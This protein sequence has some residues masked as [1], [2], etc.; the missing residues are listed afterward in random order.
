MKKFIRYIFLF[1]LSVFLSTMTYGQIGISVGVSADDLVENIVG[2]GVVYSNAT[3]NGTDVMH[4]TFVNGSTT[5][6]GIDAGIF[7]TSGSGIFIPGP[8]SSGS[9]STNNE[10]PGDGSLSGLAGGTT[11]DASVLE[12]DFIPESDTLRFQYSFGSDEYNEFVWSSYNDVFGFFVSGP[13]PEGGMY[14]NVNVAVVPGSNPPVPVAINT[15]NNDLNSE[16]YHENLTP[17]TT[18]EY[19]GFT[20]VLTA[21]IRVVPCEEYHIK[22]GVADVADGIYDSGIFL[23]EN[24]FES[25]KIDVQANP[26]PEGVADNMVEGC[27]EA[28]VVFRLPNTSYTPITVDFVVEGTAEAPDDYNSLGNSVT[29][30]EGVDSVSLH[31][32]PIA[33]YI[34]EGDEDIMIIITNTLGCTVRIDTVSFLIKDY[35][36]L[37]TESPGEVQLCENAN[38]D[39]TIHPTGGLEPFTFDWSTGEEADT[40]ETINVAPNEDTWYY[41]TVSDMCGSEVKDSV[42]VEVIPSPDIDLGNDTTLC[43]G[44]ELVLDAGEGFISYYW[45]T[46]STEQSITVTESGNYWVQVIGPG[47]CSTLDQINVTFAPALNLE[48]GND[49]SLCAGNTLNLEAPSGMQSYLWQDGSTTSTLEVTESGTYWVNIESSIGCSETD[50]IHVL[51]EDETIVDLGDDQWICMGD[52]FVL[53]PG[54]YNQYEWQDGST[55]SIYTVT[56]AGTYILQALGGCGW[57]SDT[58][59]INYHPPVLPDLGPDTTICHTDSYVLNPGLF[60]NP[61]WQDGTVANTYPV[62]ETGTYSV[63]VTALTYACTGSDTVFVRV[64]QAVQ[65]G[66]DTSFCQGD[67]ITLSSSNDFDYFEWTKDNDAEILS[68]SNS[69]LVSEEGNYTISVGINNINCNSSDEI[70]VDEIPVATADLEDG[71]ICSGETMT[72]HVDPDSTYNYYW[73]GEEGDHELVVSETG[74][75]RIKVGN[76]CGYAYDTAN[77]TVYPLPEVDL[78][79]DQFLFDENG[80]IILNAGEGFTSYTWQD[81]SSQSTYTITYETAL[82]NSEYFV[83]VFDGNCYATDSIIVE[84][85]VPEIPNLLSP[86]GDGYNDVFKPTSKWGAI[87]EHTIVIFNRWGERVWQSTDFPSGWNGENGFGRKVSNGTY[88]WVLEANYGRGIKRIYKGSLTVLNSN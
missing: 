75:Y 50:T 71:S 2:D 24:S 17:P 84:T 43:G 25:P 42:F 67:T 39:I 12:F 7:L 79:E 3:I 59:V 44:E 37:L 20:V 57:A 83:E 35:N 36:E 56:E 14:S 31:V 21:F 62:Y 15:I 55:D 63:T 46:S 16:Y 82:Q 52:D 27:V 60:L 53:D 49:T 78:G 85:G 74:T 58:I 47:G 88:Y 45:S 6:L 87:K 38:M 5:S 68:T 8:N 30:D 76:K 22:M 69:L 18:L 10:E 77:I 28:D 54:F 70:F 1:F 66:A 32:V 51:F 61:V 48:L 19:D 40:T 33:D 64:G 4:G 72:L 73:N 41:L 9:T 80:E 23:K 65:L 81:G 13:N 86:N 29:F 34:E 26:V 11:Y